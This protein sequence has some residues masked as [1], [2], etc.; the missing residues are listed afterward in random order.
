MGFNQFLRSR[1]TQTTCHQLSAVALV[2][3]PQPFLTVVRLEAWID[4]SKRAAASGKAIC[5]LC[6]LDERNSTQKSLSK[7]WLIR[8]PTTKDTLVILNPVSPVQSGPVFSSWSCEWIEH[9]TT[10]TP[11]MCTTET[12]WSEGQ[13]PRG[14]GDTLHPPILSPVMHTAHFELACVSAKATVSRM[15]PRQC[16]SWNGQPQMEKHKQEFGALG[17][18]LQGELA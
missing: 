3:D 14:K 18:V 13:C 17:R 1:T 7:G 8:N 12:H 15:R 6:M 4:Q 2:V 5:Q 10:E 9:R 16:A 11:K